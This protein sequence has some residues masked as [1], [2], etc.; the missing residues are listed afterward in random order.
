MARRLGVLQ[1][2]DKLVSR[3]DGASGYAVLIEMGLA[4]FALEAVVAR[5]PEE[6]SFEA[7][8]NSRR[9]MEHGTTR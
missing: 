3:P 2:V 9:R 4:E 6:F 1:A 5:H 8:Q 7:V